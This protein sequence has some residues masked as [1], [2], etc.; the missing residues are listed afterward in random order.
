MTN[1]QKQILEKMEEGVSMDELKEF[2]LTYT[3][4]SKK[5][6]KGLEKL[7]SV[8]KS[9]YTKSTPWLDHFICQDNLIIY[10]QGIFM[11]AV[12]NTEQ[13]RESI[14]HYQTHD[15]S[16]EIESRN[17]EN[18]L[19]VCNKLYINPWEEKDYTWFTLNVDEINSWVKSHGITKKNACENGNAIEIHG[20]FFNP[21]V[22]NKLLQLIAP[23]TQV[24]ATIHTRVSALHLVWDEGQ[25]A[26][27]GMFVRK[28]K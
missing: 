6:K 9:L 8:V 4:P 19:R 20:K 1:L 17:R 26:L 3:T 5:N 25:I 22:L 27:A 13:A 28:N 7:G 11:I 23:N 10:S 24:K 16:E 15:T 18:L 12:K 21:F 2:V 14:R